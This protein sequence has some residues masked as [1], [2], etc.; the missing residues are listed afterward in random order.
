MAAL[1]PFMQEGE[2]RDRNGLRPWE[3]G[4]DET[5]LAIADHHW[6]DFTPCMTQ[7]WRIKQHN[8][9]KILFFKLGKF[10][11]IFAMDAIICQ[12]LLDLNWMGGA[13][14]LHVGFPEKAL[15]KYLA[16]LVNNGW[17]VAVIEQTETPR[18]LEG[19]Q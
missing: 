6:K 2:I 16:I 11:E 14:K 19:R 4:Y 5:S 10:Y 12:K 18:E 15:D 13:K 3:E 7:F 8:L 1:P 9:E 17:K